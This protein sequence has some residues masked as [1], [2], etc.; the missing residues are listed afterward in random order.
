MNNFSSVKDRQRLELRPS[1]RV[2][3]LS[4][5]EFFVTNDFGLRK[6]LT[7][8]SL[9]DV[10]DILLDE[11]LDLKEQ[12][13]LFRESG[14]NAEASLQA[15]RDAG[16]VREVTY[17]SDK[18][19]QRTF[20]DILYPGG[21]VHKLRIGLAAVDEPLADQVIN[22][23][24]TM[25]DDVEVLPLSLV[26]IDVD[27]LS[28][29]DAV[30]VVYQ[31][32]TQ[33]VL[34]SHMKL[35]AA[36]IPVLYVRQL[37]SSWWIG[38]VVNGPESSCI[39]CLAFYQ[40]H[41]S[42]TDT[43]IQQHGGTEG[44][45]RAWNAQIPPLRLAAAGTIVANI[46]RI[47]AGLPNVERRVDVL[48]LTRGSMETHRLEKRPQCSVCGNPRLQA[49]LNSAPIQLKMDLESKADDGGHRSIGPEE[50]LQKYE[51]LV[52]KVSGPIS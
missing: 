47:I 17:S 37:Q 45:R 30:V 43:Y 9:K 34:D 49:Q 52:R 39:G 12:N 44:N 38:P 18:Q 25:G 19:E 5:D 10:M 3:Q 23:I 31:D 51:H 42:I 6:R 41:R 46:A 15:L 32:Y 14:S 40:K 8:S 13:K 20:W 22:D 1:L 4:D 26:N 16:L 24:E 21:D 29:C 2:T 48:D 27:K 33:S 36:S 50:F 28:S 35:T 11:T 7:G